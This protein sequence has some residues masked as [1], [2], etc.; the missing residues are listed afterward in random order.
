[1]KA[2]DKVILCSLGALV[3]GLGVVGVVGN[4]AAKEVGAT[5]TTQ[6]YAYS[7]SPNKFGGFTFSDF[8]DKD[9]YYLVPESTT[10]GASCLISKAGVLGGSGLNVD[11][12]QQIIVT[13]NHAT[14]GSGSDPSAST[15]SFYNDTTGTGTA[16][17]AT[18]G[19]SLANSKTFVDV[20]YTFA[21][22]AFSGDDL[23][24]KV[25]KPGKTIRFKSFSIKYTAS[26]APAKTVSSLAAS[27]TPT[28]TSY[29]S[30][31]IFDP[32]GLTVT[33]TYSDSSTAD[34]TSSIIWPALSAGTSITGSFGGKT[35]E[36]TGLTVTAAPSYSLVSSLDELGYDAD[37]LIGDATNKVSLGSYDSTNYRFA[38]QEVLV[39]DNSLA[40]SKA[41]VL[42]LKFISKGVYA[43]QLKGEAKYL[44]AYSSTT[45][46]ELVEADSYSDDAAKWT[47]SF[48][49]SVAT[50]T[51]VAD[52]TYKIIGHN[53]ASTAYFA[54]YSSAKVDLGIYQKINNPLTN[55]AVSGSLV[56]S[57][58]YTSEAFDPN[59]LTVNA[60][61]DG[62][63]SPVDVSGLVSWPTANLTVGQTTVTGTFISGG[64]TKT[65]VS[66][67]FTVQEN[68]LQ[69]IAITT[70]ANKTSYVTGEKL[71]T[72]GLVVT[73]TWAS[74]Q[75]DVTADCTFSP[76]LTAELA[77]NDNTVTITYQGKTTS[78]AIS[79]RLAIKYVKVT[80]VKQLIAGA[81]VYIAKSPADTATETAV[82]S[83]TQN[84][85]NRGEVTA[86]LDA[87]KNIIETDNAA[88]ITIGY[89]TTNKTYYTLNA[90]STSTN[91]YLYAASSSNNYLRSQETVDVNAEWRITITSGVANVVATGSSNRNI[92]QYN[93]SS[94][95]FSAYSSAQVAI[96]LYVQENY[97]TA[98]DHANTCYGL[99]GV[100][101]L[102]ATSPAIASDDLK[103]A[104]TLIADDYAALASDVKTILASA[105]AKIDGGYAEELAA[106]YDYIMKKYGVASFTEGNFMSR[107]ESGASSVLGLQ[108]NESGAIITIA[109]V[110]VLGLLTTAGVFI[111]KKKHN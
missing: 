15:F 76:A 11:K 58:F 32:T 3:L 70:P 65:V 33:A 47:I 87:S 71:D 82:M 56:R 98:A 16:V 55:L 73:A 49:G 68:V 96:A 38:T 67:A 1:M 59:G 72:T 89:G 86:T 69:S 20:T 85:N 93:S 91:E 105:S 17:T 81:K 62:V 54:C 41:Q 63:A 74:G 88:A 13:I 7:D 104:W 103:S 4:Q 110:G 10:S 2:F 37:I 75:T 94:S 27:G 22:N 90:S 31:E 29:Y 34:V 60:T 101:C 5:T 45:K 64:V 18:Q 30:D 35:I 108:G 92:L 25:T 48:A 40:S 95:I 14:Y 97:V 52:Y 83:T 99:L 23:C 111:L 6:T 107:D 24:I 80:D 77:V 53:N 43:L 84:G 9:S 44:A 109:S 102:G 36:I 100:A 19:G 106:R 8:T 51:S 66:P 78:Y 61:F 50:I 42:T 12:A 57:S 39:S 21:A 28:K 26:T 46:S 79:V